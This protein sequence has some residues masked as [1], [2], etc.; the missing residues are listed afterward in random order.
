M[1][2]L[3]EI[4]MILTSLMGRIFFSED[5]MITSVF[6][7]KSCSSLENIGGGQISSLCMGVLAVTIVFLVM[8]MWTPSA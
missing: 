6:L 4:G 7:K 8:T 5:V 2:S 3:M 1:A